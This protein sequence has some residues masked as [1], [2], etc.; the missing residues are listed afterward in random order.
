MKYKLLAFEQMTKIKER[1]FTEGLKIRLGLISNALD[2]LGFA[3]VDTSDI[4]I[5]FTHDLPENEAEI[6]QTVSLLKDI[7]TKDQLV[8]L[9]PYDISD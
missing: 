7:L 6:A 9:L 2:V 5:I 4:S 1:Y 8:K 3:K